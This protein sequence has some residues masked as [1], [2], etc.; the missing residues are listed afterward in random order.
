MFIT[1]FY[2]NIFVFD[3]FIFVSEVFS[4]LYEEMICTMQGNQIHVIKDPLLIWYISDLFN[5]MLPETITGKNRTVI[6]NKSTG[7]PTCYDEEYSVLKPYPSMESSIRG[8]PYVLLRRFISADLVRVIPFSSITKL[9]AK[10]FKSKKVIEIT[11]ICPFS[12]KKKIEKIKYDPNLYS[13]LVS[14]YKRHQEK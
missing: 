8:I 12:G 13:L 3:S 11:Y 1:E 9:K 14:F 6:K 2:E 7:T 4:K 10:G 5:I